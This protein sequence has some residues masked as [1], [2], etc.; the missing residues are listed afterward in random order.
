MNMV[1]PHMIFTLTL[2]SFT[3][4]YWAIF[5]WY[6]HNM[7]LLAHLTKQSYNQQFT[8]RSLWSEADKTRGWQCSSTNIHQ[9][10]QY[11][12]QCLP[13]RLLLGPFTFP[14]KQNPWSQWNRHLV[15][16]LVL[17]SRDQD[18]L[19]LPDY[20]TA[21][22]HTPQGSIP[23]IP[24]YHNTCTPLNHSASSCTSWHG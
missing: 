24:S 6:A 9:S 16:T 14:Y 15:K 11:Y 21:W 10:L 18:L 20:M 2:Y 19:H 12:W 8:D 13:G 5:L 17:N 22:F 7:L 1:S 3:S 4:A 23:D